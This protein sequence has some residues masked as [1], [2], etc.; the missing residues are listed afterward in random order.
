ME[1]RMGY[2]NTVRFSYLDSLNKGGGYIDIEYI[3]NDEEKAFF[4]ATS[5]GRII[6]FKKNLT[7]FYQ[8]RFI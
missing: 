3:L 5:T 4:N 7:A 2:N 6:W 8:N 1:F